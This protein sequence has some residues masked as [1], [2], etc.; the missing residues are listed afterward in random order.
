MAQATTTKNGFNTAS[1]SGSGVVWDNLSN[2][3]YPTEGE[4]SCDLN[5]SDME[6]NR[7]A[8]VA[9]YEML[10][11]QTGA[12]FVEMSLYL[13]LKKS[14]TFSALTNVTW[15]GKMNLSS[16]G[17]WTYTLTDDETYK[18]ITISGDESYWRISSL[19]PSDIIEKL[20]TGNLYCQVDGELTFATNCQI[21]LKSATCQ[22][23]YITVDGQRASL[24]AQMI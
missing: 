9:P 13:S 11:V 22:I 16:S 20:R 8:L 19:S 12:Q 23:T 3:P 6:A 2:V 24:I 1:Q 15:S 18:N 4:A 5:A 14:G 17:V 21:L 10:N 7:V